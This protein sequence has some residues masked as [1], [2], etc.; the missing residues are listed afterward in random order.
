MH[1]A[2]HPVVRSVATSGRIVV[3]GIVRGQRRVAGLIRL[4]HLAP[5]DLLMVQADTP[6]LEQAL[7][8]GDTLTEVFTYTLVD[9]DGDVSTAT[10]TI[11]IV[12][13]N[14]APIIGNGEA[15]VSEEGLP[16]GLPDTDGTS[17]TT[18]SP[19]DSGT[20]SVSDPDGD[21]VTVSLS[22][23]GLPALTSNTVP[24]VWALS[25]G[26]HTL[27]RQRRWRDDHHHHHR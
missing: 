22:T 8:D 13:T 10:L 24:I 5:G 17:D 2:L 18:D 19:T 14:E 7:G 6:A 16:N 15:V 1:A 27:T 21:P 11:T 25:D 23:S 3:L 26:G 4:E 20:I 9:G 12:G